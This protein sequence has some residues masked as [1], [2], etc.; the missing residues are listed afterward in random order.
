MNSDSKK[1]ALERIEILFRLAR[2]TIHEKPD[3]AQRYVE[4][5]RKIS[6]KT[7]LHLPP[8]YHIQICRHCKMFILPGVNA[9]VRVQTRRNPHIVIS[10]LHCGGK[11]RMPLEGKKPR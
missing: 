1:V 9:Q 8:E 10:C 6:M 3:L 4:L 2:E 7:R 11:M 5:A